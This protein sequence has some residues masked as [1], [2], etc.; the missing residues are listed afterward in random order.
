MIKRCKVSVIVVCAPEGPTDRDT[1]DSDE[2]YLLLHEQIN[3]IPVRNM[4]FLLG[5]FDA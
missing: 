5:N 2:F 1:S 3:R 4:V